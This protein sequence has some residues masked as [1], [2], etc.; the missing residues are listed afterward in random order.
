MK[1]KLRQ[2]LVGFLVLIIISVMLRMGTWQLERHAWRQQFNSR[3][4]AQLDQP[5]LD[6]NQSPI[7]GDLWDME[8]RMA[9]VRGV[10]DYSEEVLLRN[11][12]WVEPGQA[13][14]GYHVLTPLIIQGSKQ[15]IYINRGWIPLGDAAPEKRAT[16][17]E[18]GVQTVR[19]VIRRPQTTPE[20]GG[21][22]DPTRIPGQPRQETWNLVNLER[23]QEQ[24]TLSLLPVYLQQSP[25][26]SWQ[27]LPYRSEPVLEITAG[28]HIFFA[29]SWFALAAIVLY[30]YIRSLT[31][32]PTAEVGGK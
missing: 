28:N 32:K 14:P 5:V 17:Q 27:S 13:L 18:T 1:H 15:A 19:G 12:V 23:L 4:L 2:V 9:E 16:Y 6:L 31:K 10:Y 11:Q 7:P 22:P 24:T 21:I 3:V 26:P 30:F 29:I 20:I 8:Y 25:D